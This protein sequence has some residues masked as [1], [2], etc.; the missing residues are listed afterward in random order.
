[1]SFFHFLSTA[2]LKFGV[3]M[4]V[5]SMPLG[6]QQSPRSVQRGMTK[7]HLLPERQELLSCCLTASLPGH[8]SSWLSSPAWTPVWETLEAA[9]PHKG[10]SCWQP[11]A[12]AAGRAVV[13]LGQSL[14][15]CT[16]TLHAP[17]WKVALLSQFPPSPELGQRVRYGVLWMRPLFPCMGF[18]SSL[19][20]HRHTHW[21]FWRPT[22]CTTHFEP[23][24]SEARSS[25]AISYVKHPSLFCKHALRT[26]I[27]VYTSTQ[28]HQYLPRLA[29]ANLLPSHDKPIAKFQSMVFSIWPAVCL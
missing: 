10:R 23:A 29:K 15:P 21:C 12:A 4:P 26:Y 16:L 3:E 27:C 28:L 24:A 25:S 9:A 7:T 11:G 13:C 8:G 20:D 1:M 22:Y 2:T 14:S 6:T 18:C 5:A 19:W 17:Q